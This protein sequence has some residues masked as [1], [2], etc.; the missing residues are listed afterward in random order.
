MAVLQPGQPPPPDYYADNLGFVLE[1][2]ARRNDDLLSTRERHLMLNWRAS[3]PPARRLFARLQSRKGPWFRVDSLFYPELKPDLSPEPAS[4]QTPA[5][6]TLIDCARAALNELAERNLITRLPDAPADALLALLTVAELRALWPTLRSRRKDALIAECVSSRTDQALR[7]RLSTAHPWV[8]IADPVA[9]A[10]LETLFFGHDRGELS[11]FILQD[12]GLRQFERY[13]IG[14]HTRPFPDRESFD[15]FAAL[16]RLGRWLDERGAHPGDRHAIGRGLWRT[17]PVRI[18]ARQ[19]N[20]L[21]NR[22]GALH[23]RAGA[24]DEALDSYARSEAHPARERRIRLL[25]RLHDIRGASVLARRASSA[26]WSGDEED[27]VDRWLAKHAGAKPAAPRSRS[28]ADI[29]IRPVPVTS[30]AARD[31]MDRGIESQACDDFAAMGLAAW[32]MENLLPLGLAGLLF[33]DVVFAPVE[34]AFSHPLQ[35]GPR[36]LFWPDFAERRRVL[37]DDRLAVLGDRAIYESELRR[38]YEQKHGISNR[39][40]AW[41]AWCEARLAAFLVVPDHERILALAAHVIQHLERARTGFPDLL[42]YDPALGISF[43]EV[44]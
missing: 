30:E 2:A 14:P 36:D 35:A 7:G 40:V 22:L 33:W 24:F 11:T 28:S 25:T 31:F 18:V 10:R 29:D 1:E 32:H 13:D 15:H 38:V 9:L 37:I 27:F 43:C 3:S 6:S 19:R 41:P 23:E 20:R 39:L 42:I 21:L 12:L 26:P 34:G 4:V 16:R 5:D 8:A 17:T 44:K